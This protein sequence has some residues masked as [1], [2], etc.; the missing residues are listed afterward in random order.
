MA[1]ILPFRGIRYDVEKAGELP[2]LLA[3]P[4][5]VV[6]SR[7]RER[8]LAGSSHNIFALELPDAGGGENPYQHVGQLFREWLSKGV[9]IQDDRP[10]VYPYDITFKAN[11]SGYC[12][13]GL[14]SLVRLEEW[15]SGVVKPHEQTFDQVTEDR[16]RLLDATHAQFSQVFML[17]RGA[18]DTSGILAGAPR[19][20]L[21]EVTDAAGNIHSLSRVTDPDALRELHGSMADATLYIADGHH[22]YTTAL[23]FRRR[24]V[25]LHGDDPGRGYNYLMAYLVD[26]QDP[27]LVVLPTHRVVRL[28]G[29]E[30]IA[31]LQ[32]AAGEFFHVEELGHLEGP[33]EKEALRLAE[34]LR[35][36]L[37]S[38]PGRQGIGVVFG[39]GKTAQ[40]WWARQGAG[41]PVQEVLGRLPRVLSMLDVVLFR[42]VV[43]NG[44][45]GLDPDDRV[46]KRAIRYE[47]DAA[48]AICRLD[49]CEVLF[50]LRPTPVA[51]VIDVADAGLTMPHKST[52]FYPKILTGLVLN[53]LDTPVELP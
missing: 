51:Q 48:G 11:G 52:F 34:R 6:S 2:S 8:L 50:F 23:G 37:A 20:R 27:G 12:R 33:G 32:G 19:D 40:V 47:A 45:L 18:G 39:P 36:A 46:H 49:D 14:V 3:P 13:R 16:F 29:R 25:E 42:K 38:S 43:L 30:G 35:Q 5:D 17:C 22:R 15:D 28:P 31:R 1:Q 10:A 44:I 9:L 21:Y 7:Q 41:S 53:S 4:Y 26:V 24:M